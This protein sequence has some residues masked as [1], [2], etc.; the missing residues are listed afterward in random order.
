MNKK[1]FN[2]LEEIQKYYDEKSNT[3]I[4]KENDDF[5]VELVI[6]NFDL[7]VEANI[8]ACNIDADNIE[9]L[10]IRARNIN[11]DNI[12]AR[13][14]D[15]F[16][17]NALDVTAR[18][19]LVDNIKARNIDAREIDCCDTCVASENIKCKSIIGGRIED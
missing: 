7:K 10:D 11:A 2:N 12:K 8:R 16:D 6:F 15:A 5:L 14:I 3:Y 1:E 18:D 9:A 17:I 4:F 19:I 13:D